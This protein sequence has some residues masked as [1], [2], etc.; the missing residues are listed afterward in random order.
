[1]EKRLSKRTVSVVL[2]IGMI[3]AFLSPQWKIQAEAAAAKTFSLPIKYHTSISKTS[4]ANLTMTY[5]TDTVGRG[6]VITITGIPSGAYLSNGGYEMIDFVEVNDQGQ[7][8]AITYFGIDG[9]SVIDKGSL[10]Y[11][12]KNDPAGIHLL[13]GAYKNNSGQ[14]VSEG[15]FALDKNGIVLDMNT[16][17]EIVGKSAPAAD[18]SGLANAK[19]NNSEFNAQ[20]YYDQNPD[21]QVAIGADAPALYDHWVNYGKAEGRKAK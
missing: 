17:K 6:T 12:V 4:N 7:D 18:T 11:T 21:L 3:F 20:V 8:L 5:S 9:G 16:K 2:L 13:I 15:W 19:V 14:L 1:M 10:T